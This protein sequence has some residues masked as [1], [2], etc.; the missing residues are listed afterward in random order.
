MNSDVLTEVNLVPLLNGSGNQS[1]PLIAISWLVG[2]IAVGS[3]TPHLITMAGSPHAA[4]PASDGL[5]DR[6]S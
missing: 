6:M 5:V 2:V 4:T 3:E 1:T